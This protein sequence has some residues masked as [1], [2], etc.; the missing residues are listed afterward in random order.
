VLTLSVF[1]KKLF[2]EPT[3]HPQWSDSGLKIDGKAHSRFVPIADLSRCSKPR[4]WNPDLLDHLVS[5]G[6]HAWRDCK[7]ERLGS[8]HVDDEL[9]FGRLHDRKISGFLTPENPSGKESSLVVPVLNL[10]PIGHQTASSGEFPKLERRGNRIAFRERS[11]L[12][13]RSANKP[14][15]VIMSA[16]AF[17]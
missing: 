4:V 16:P 11:D 12:I 15:A 8:L 10:G 14:S 13:K 17:S 3:A 5:N 6:E 9:E 2:F 7:A 1:F